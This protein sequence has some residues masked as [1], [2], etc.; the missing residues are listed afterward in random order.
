MSTYAPVCERLR[1]SPPLDV[2]E[3]TRPRLEDAVLF[4]TSWGMTL[5]RFVSD[6]PPFQQDPTRPTQD[7]PARTV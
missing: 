3:F 5:Q 7:A 2:P 6:A 4:W 1:A